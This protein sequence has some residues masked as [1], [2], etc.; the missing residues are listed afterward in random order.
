MFLTSRQI[1]LACA[2]APA[3]LG[4]WSTAGRTDAA[5]PAP[6]DRFEKSIAPILARNCVTCHNSSDPKGELDLT[7]RSGLI[8]GGSS[9]AAAAPGQPDESLLLERVTEGSMPP[10]KQGQRLT[11]VE[12]ELLRAW[13]RDGAAWPDDRM[14][15]AFEFTTDKRA[16]QDWWSLQPVR[17]PAVPAVRRADWDRDPI[18]RF[19][20]SAL[21]QRGLEP[22]P[23][24]S[25]A[26]YLRRAKFDLLGLPPTP[27][28][29]DAFVN[30]DAPDACDR[31]I[32]R[33]LASPHYGERWGRH[34]LD[35][36]RFGESDGFEND[37]FRDHAWPYRDYV[38]R[39]LN[40]DKPYAQFVQEQLAGDVLQ[41]VTRDGIAATGFLVAGPWD[42]VQN[43]GKSKLERMRTHEEQIE[44]LIGAVSQTFLGMTVNCA[45]CHDHKFD[46]IPQTDYYRMK[47]VFDGVDHG[48]RPLFTPPEQQTHQAKVAPIQARIDD[49]K[50]RLEVVKSQGPSDAQITAPDRK[51]LLVEGRFDQGL[52]GG[53]GQVQTPAKPAFTQPPLTVECWTRLNSKSQ[54]NILVASNPKES[55]AHWEIYSY[56]GSG[57]F[58]AYLPGYAPAEIK[59]GVDITDGKWHYVALL[60]DSQR[61]QLFVDGRQ[62]R[63]TAVKQVRTDAP[64]GALYFGSYPPQKILCDGSVDEVRISSGLRTIDRVPDGPFTP[65]D[66]TAGLWHF[67]TIDGDRFAE[68]SGAGGALP[69]N[70]ARRQ[71]DALQAEIKQ[72]EAELA[73]HPVPMVYS[74]KRREPEPTVV[75][76][77]GAIDQPGPQVTP[78]GLAP[79]KMP[80]P[81]LDLPAGAPEAER[82][83]KFAA[84][85]TNADHPLTARVMV[86]RIWQYHFGQGL[87][88]TA[89]DLGFNG[90]KP[91]HP[92]LLDWLAAEFMAS[93]TGAGEGP[94]PH[95][96]SIKRLH[97][98]ILLSATYR[99]S[100]R[101]DPRAAALDADNKL[102]WRYAPRRLEGEIVRD[103][104]LAVS[105]ELNPRLGGPSFRPFTVTVFLTYFYHLVDE[106]TPEFNRRT[107]YRMNINTGRSP[108]LDSLDCPA[109]SIA[110]PRRGN[111]TTPLQALALMNDSFV[112]R[113]AA[114]FSERVQKVAGPDPAAQVAL[115]Y[116]LAFGRIPSPDEAG[117]AV[118]LLQEHGLDSVCWTLLNASEFLY[119]K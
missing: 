80:A 53:K 37:K 26:D 46:P 27:D 111:T 67:D 73:A 16:G 71:Q 60:F 100:S 74:G 50:K 41:P 79:V 12:V 94:A 61:V 99:Q 38:I 106:G 102:L 2:L 48:N 69:A 9:G 66:Q 116:R 88:A 56:A 52:A 72:Q 25:R 29:I 14:L 19:V 105:G 89:N 44:E 113:Q 47:A 20:L 92:E 103:A 10:P 42:E 97:K 107:V 109:P 87:V 1:W 43:V 39:S 55:A 32:D 77:R 33:L 63:D 21:E 24:A 86:N 17:R 11:P 54:F 90:G 85:A 45:R 114:R 68:A 35:V 36:V 78:G 40:E 75:Y 13:I 64:G 49:L 96:W 93:D 8:K 62:V 118:R 83:L 7:R 3:L 119:V 95:A 81:D 5:E 76:L 91:S 18:D 51:L 28:E 70:E 112:V 108:L 6:G 82:R 58:S 117:P 34:W 23:K 57:E 22:A 31:L 84:W 4:A 98:R 65:D 101:F 15:S 30:D 59:S 104:M 115:A 110:A